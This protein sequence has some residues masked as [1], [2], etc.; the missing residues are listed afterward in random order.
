M[1]A[2]A[3]RAGHSNDFELLL[4]E[5]LVSRKRQSSGMSSGPSHKN[6][7]ITRHAVTASYAA[8]LRPNNHASKNSHDTELQPYTNHSRA[9]HSAI[10]LHR[11]LNISSSRIVQPPSEAL[12][13][14]L[15]A[16]FYFKLDSMPNF[17]I[18]HTS[19]NSRVQSPN[20]DH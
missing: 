10:Q 19:R 15:F 1:Q 12:T 20:Y 11:V 14:L 16:V 17:P 9:V 4:P 2:D 13:H 6:F 8:Y 3:M 18:I 7:H 5:K